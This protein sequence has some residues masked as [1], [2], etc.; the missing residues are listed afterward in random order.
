MNLF[1]MVSNPAFPKLKYWKKENFQGKNRISF[2]GIFFL[3]SFLFL[4]FSISAG[5]AQEMTF[6]AEVDKTEV[7]AGESVKLTLT[8][9]KNLSDASYSGLN[10]PQI[11]GIPDFD[12]VSQRSA[13]NLSFVNGVGVAK[14]QVLLELVP[15][16]QGDLTIPSLSIKS[17]S[18]KL[19]STRAITIK[20]HPPKDESAQDE[21]QASST[22]QESEKKGIGFFQGL[23]ILFLVVLLVVASPIILS[24]LL[25]RGAKPSSKW[26]EPASKTNLSDRKYEGKEEIEDALIIEET[27]ERVQKIDFEVEVAALKKQ[28]P[29][30]DRELFKRYF[31]LFHKAILHNFTDLEPS[32]TPN[33]LMDRISGKLPREKIPMITKITEDW[34]LVEFANMVPARSFSEILSDSR[35]I[36]SYMD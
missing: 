17:P 21:P 18:G 6:D 28:Y 29:D 15:Q 10:I 20:A 35:D 1:K 25:T 7:R 11:N 36:L 26:K 33:E 13:Q 31:S 9:T 16:K 8:I 34:E 24:W 2:A 30:A 27:S 5:W 14:V 32:L 19:L 4:I 23:V 3:T 22:V 12:I